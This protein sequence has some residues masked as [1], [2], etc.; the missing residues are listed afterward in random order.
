MVSYA[1]GADRHCA[2][3]KAVGKGVLSGQSLSGAVAI[4]SGPVDSTMV[5]AATRSG[6]SAILSRRPLRIRPSSPPV[7]AASSSCASTAP[8][9][10]A[11]Y[12]GEEA[13]SGIEFYKDRPVEPVS[14]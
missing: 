3:W 10:R 2:L 14:W 13:L 1:V 12:S 9:V 11:I 5:R 8:P 4:C 6:M 7:R